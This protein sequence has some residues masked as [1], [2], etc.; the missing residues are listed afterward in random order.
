MI[1]MGMRKKDIRLDRAFGQVI[2]HHKVAEGT[3]PGTGINNNKP[4][5]VPHPQFNAGSVTT[6]LLGFRP[7]AG[8]RSPHTPKANFHR[9]SYGYDPLPMGELIIEN[10]ICFPRNRYR[11]SDPQPGY[12]VEA[13][14]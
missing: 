8:Y 6:I 1:P 3:N 11:A 2:P 7:G 12:G 10:T 4:V 5:I 14:F 13:N 9:N